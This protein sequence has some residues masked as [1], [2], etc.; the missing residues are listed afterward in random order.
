MNSRGFLQGNPKWFIPNT[1]YLPAARN[2]DPDGHV[3]WARWSLGDFSEHHQGRNASRGSARNLCGVVNLNE[4]VSSN[5]GSQVS[6]K[7]TQKIRSA[8]RK[9]ALKDQ[10]R[11]MCTLH[12]LRC[13]VARRRTRCKL[14]TCWLV[15]GGM[16]RLTCNPA[17]PATGRRPAR[18]GSRS[19]V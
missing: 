2:V 8:Q 16:S 18:H 4:H 12:Q 15:S 6:N 5:R 7:S 1:G 10:R 11:C 19:Q 17:T 14:E 9:R 3:S 13:K